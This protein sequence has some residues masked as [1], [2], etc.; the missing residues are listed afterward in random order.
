VDQ[1]RCLIG[2]YP[3]RGARL[4]LSSLAAANSAAVLASTNMTTSAVKR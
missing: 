1:R 2:G 3:F 4:I